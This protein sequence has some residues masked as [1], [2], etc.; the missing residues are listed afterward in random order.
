MKRAWYLQLSEEQTPKSAI[1]VGDRARVRMLQ[2]H[3]NDSQVLNEDRGLLTVVGNY[4]GTDVVAV[5]F[6]MGAPIAAV[7]AHEL[8]NLGVT[9]ILRLGTMMRIGDTKLGDFI[10]ADQARTEDGTSLSYMGERDLFNASARL[11]AEAV[12]ACHRYGVEPIVGR[13]MSVDGFYSAMMSIDLPQQ[14]NVELQHKKYADDQCVGLDMESAVLFALA[15]LYDV[16]V[17]SVC[18]ATVDGLTKEKLNE[19]ARK[20]GEE[21]LSLIGLACLSKGV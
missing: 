12:E 5:A 16:E 20:D 3:M 15:E 14:A 1:L 9:N 10:V 8:I 21:K 13:A 11:T 2:S 19:S 18:L 6:G 4:Q 17:G 7:V